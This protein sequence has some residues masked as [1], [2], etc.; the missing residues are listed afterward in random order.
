MKQKNIFDLFR[1]KQKILR[2]K[3][4]LVGFDGF[5]DTLAKPVRAG[6]VNSDASN[7]TSGGAINNT[8]SGVNN[9]DTRAS[10]QPA[11]FNTIAEFGEFIAAHAHSG[12]CIEYDARQRRAGGNM[13]NFVKAL[14]AL[15]LPA[16]AI[17]M[18]SMEMGGI[19]PLFARICDNLYS[20]APSGTA[21]A[22]EFDD[23]K[24][25]F[26]PRF[27]LSADPLSL[28]QTALA[29]ASFEALLAEADLLAMLNWA[30]LPF[31]QKLWRDIYTLIHEPEK[32]KNRFVFFD[33]CDVSRK[34]SAEITA[35]LELIGD[36]S[37]RRQTVL[38]LNKNE[39]NEIAR[40][41]SL[42]KDA[43]FTTLAANI[44]ARFAIDEVL[45][46]QHSESLFV[47]AE[48][49]FSCPTELSVQ[50][51]VSTGAGDNF[52]AAWCCARLSGLTPE[53]CLT[54][55]NTCASLYVTSGKSP[56]I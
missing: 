27:A 17:G 21:T 52:N 36:F 22:M 48:G 1:E 23:G 6:G 40:H 29:P 38:S 55:A 18:L 47:S 54:F 37:A 49:I 10:G 3:K 2:Q 41:I 5:I 42:E 39:A 34:S 8:N 43:P 11:Y 16:T 4:A 15:S 19:D 20:Y 30:E 7:S 25:F 28:I 46:H 56:H 12:A 33:L 53:E 31:A 24:L 44:R 14:T 9:R 51:V 50:P 13:P 35:V 32:N 26:T 45:I